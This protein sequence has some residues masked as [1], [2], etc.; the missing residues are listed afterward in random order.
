MA[1]DH[2]QRPPQTPGPATTPAGGE[3]ITSSPR[4]AP[5]SP[6]ARP[7]PAPGSQGTLATWVGRNA[8]YVGIGV[9]VGAVAA[10]A[11]KV[12]LD[13]GLAQA[14]ALATIVGLATG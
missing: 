12:G 11:L 9:L 13:V 8:R 2:I 5:A 14:A 4:P 1:D 7:A 6:A 10:L 3:Q